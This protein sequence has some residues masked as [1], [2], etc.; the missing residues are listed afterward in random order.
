MNRRTRRQ[1]LEDSMFAAAAAAGAS[2][3]VPLLAAEPIGIPALRNP[4]GSPLPD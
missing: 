2:C 4:A 1:F 3:A